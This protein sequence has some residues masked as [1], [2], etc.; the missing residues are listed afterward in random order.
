MGCGPIRKI[1]SAEPKMKL[2]HSQIKLLRI[3][4]PEIVQLYELYVEAKSRHA[5]GRLE[6]TLV[7]KIL[8]IDRLKFLFKAF[9]AFRQ[10]GSEELFQDFLDFAMS[11]W[12]YCTMNSSEI[13]KFAF[14]LYDSSRNGKVDVENLVTLVKD[15]Y[16]YEYRNN[17]TAK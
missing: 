4:N 14:D 8:E 12:N 13:A 3:G 1:Y 2:W 16:G 15:L 11:L 5:L 7:F 10:D 17:E 6:V 9:A